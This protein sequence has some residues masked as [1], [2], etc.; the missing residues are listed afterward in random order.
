MKR[1]RVNLTDV[2]KKFIFNNSSIMTIKEIADKLNRQ[3][4]TIRNF[5]ISNNIAIKKGRNYLSSGE[6]DFIYENQGVLSVTE[7][8]RQLNRSVAT[9]HNFC[10]THNLIIKRGTDVDYIKENTE[11]DNPFYS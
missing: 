10:R 5:C 9:I 7:I 11:P 6:I 2:E 1:Q 8:A 3:H 4:C